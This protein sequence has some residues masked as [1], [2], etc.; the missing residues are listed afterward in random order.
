MPFL[1]DLLQI[2]GYIEQHSVCA[3]LIVVLIGVMIYT[4]RSKDKEIKSKENELKGK[5][6]LIV[7]LQQSNKENILY[8]YAINSFESIHPEFTLKTM[9]KINEFIQSKKNRNSL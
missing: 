8:E 9:E 4:I 2:V 6:E 7:F 3:A 5:D 1:A